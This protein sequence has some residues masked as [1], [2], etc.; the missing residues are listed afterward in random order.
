MA[1]LLTGKDLQ[2]LLT[3][4]ELIEKG[5]EVIAESLRA[6]PHEDGTGHTSWLAFPLAEGENK[7]NIVALTTPKEATTL[8]VWPTD[9]AAAPD[10][11]LTMLFDRE[12]GKLR[13]LMGGDY[14]MWRTAG[15]VVVACR[16]LAPAG[17]RTVAMLGSGVQARYHLIGLKH[18]LPDLERINVYSHTEANARKYAD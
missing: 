11:A 3:D 4:P 8:R 2:P 5:L 18:A 6:T 17:T 1:L 12:Q 15:P 9:H 14:L 16:A 7:L 13:A 10:V